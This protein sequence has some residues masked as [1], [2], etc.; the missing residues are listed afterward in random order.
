MSKIAVGILCIVILF[1]LLALRMWVGLAMTAAG[2]VGLVIMRGFSGAWPLLFSS[3]FNNVCS[4][5]LSVMPMFVLM[6]CV[7]SET[8]IGSDLYDTM[9]KWLGHHKG[10]LS[11]ATVLA[12]GLLGAITGSQMTGAI[13][14]SKVALPEMEKQNY[15]ETLACGCIAAAS[16]LGILIPPSTAFIV[17][18][19]LTER[20]IG[21]LFISGIVP[22]LITIVVFFAAIFIICR[23]DPELGPALK[24]KFPLKVRLKALV[25]I[26]PIVIL[27]VV[28]MVFIY[29]G[30]T[31]A[32]EAGAIGAFG[33]LIITI[34]NRQLTWQKFRKSL[35]ETATLMGMIMLQMFGTYVFS[36]ALTFSGITTALGKVVIGLNAPKF[37]I[38]IAIIILYMI[39]G[40][41]LPEFPMIMLTVPILYPIVQQ[42]GFDLIWFGVL[43]V[44]I[45]SIGMMTPPVGMIVFALSGIAKKPTGMIFKGVIPFLIAE[46]VVVVLLC[47][48]PAI[49]TWLPSIM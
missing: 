29:L 25:T 33:A 3:T 21:K 12:T 11:Y 28:V 10:G 35:R 48:F 23:K 19:L 8:R 15:K 44:V 36:V 22:G 41:F 32:T 38:I 31:T 4:Y 17:Y 34:A 37:V 20:S 6:G 16:P 9:H 40:C 24:E 5:S 26:L 43:I 2:F 42:L 47:A 1:A 45:M 27:F 13:V 30:W 49:A 14:M 18:G 39:L 46:V 7:I